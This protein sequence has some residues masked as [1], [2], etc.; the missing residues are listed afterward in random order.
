MVATSYGV[1]PVPV[2]P[3]V[4][5]GIIPVFIPLIMR[6]PSARRDIVMVTPVGRV[7]VTRTTPLR[8]NWIVTVACPEAPPGSRGAAA[9]TMKL[10]IEKVGI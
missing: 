2:E 5:G 7:A 1:P 3:V 10:Q 8:P 6:V 4:G 9:V